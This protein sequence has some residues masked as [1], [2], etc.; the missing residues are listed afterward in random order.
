M[1]HSSSRSFST[2]VPV[3]AMRC[4]AGSARAAGFLAGEM[5]NPEKTLP[6]ALILGITAVIGLYLATNLAGAIQLQEKRVCI[7]DLGGNNPAQAEGHGD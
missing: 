5:R 1:L 2:G 7:A 3:A 6:R 4:V